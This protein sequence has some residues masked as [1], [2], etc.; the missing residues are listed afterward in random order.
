MHLPGKNVLTLQMLKDFTKYRRL[1]Q[2]QVLYHQTN[3]Q[4]DNK[5]IHFAEIVFDPVWYRN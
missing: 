5:E 3:V 4:T 2:M 1:F